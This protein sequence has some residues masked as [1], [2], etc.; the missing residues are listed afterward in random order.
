MPTH[1]SPSIRYKL[2]TIGALL[3]MTAAL[4]LTLAVLQW[5]LVDVRVLKAAQA[6]AALKSSNGQR[7]STIKPSTPHR[8]RDL[9]TQRDHAGYQSPA[10]LAWQAFLPYLSDWEASSLSSTP[11]YTLNVVNS[12]DGVEALQ[13]AADAGHPSAQF[14]MGVAAMTG[15]WP[16]VE[17]PPGLSVQEQWLDRSSEQQSSALIL[18]HMAAISGHTEAMLA[19]AYRLEAHLSDQPTK[20]TCPQR[21]PY[22]RAAA[23]AMMDALLADSHSRA[24]VAPPS[25]KH[26]LHQ[27]HLFGG[28]QSKLDSNNKADESSDALQFYHTRALEAGDHSPHA[29]YTLA[30][31]YHYGL[32]GVVQNLTQALEYYELAAGLGHW[33]AAGQAGKF[34]LY[35]M[36][37]AADLYKAQKYFESGMPFGLD[38]CRKKLQLKLQQQNTKSESDQEIFLCDANCLNGMGVLSLLGLPMTVAVDELKAEEHFILAKDQGNKDA[39]YNLAMMKAGWKSHYR[40]LE[41]N[42]QSPKEEWR[43]KDP[44]QLPEHYLTHPEVQAVLTDLTVAASGGHLQAKHRLAKLYETGAKAPNRGTMMTVIQPDCEKAI[45]NYRFIIDTASPERSRRLRTAYKQYVAGDRAASLRNYLIAAETG[46]D[47]AQLNAA[48]LLEQGEC[49]GLDRLSCAKAALRLWKA[50]ADAGHVEA[51]L[52]VGDFYYYGRLRDSHEGIV[53]PFGWA[54][55]LLYP[56]RHL[57]RLFRMAIAELVRLVKGLE[58]VEEKEVEPV[59]QAGDGADD[60]TCAAPSAEQDVEHSLEKDLENAAVYYRS[61]ADRAASPRANYNLAFLYEWGLGL[62]QDFHLAKRHYDLAIS[63]STKMEAE[64][65]VFIALLCLKIHAYVVKVWKTWEARYE[66]DSEVFVPS[67]AEVTGSEGRPVPS[68]RRRTPQPEEVLVVLI[69]HLLSWDTLL[70]V[71]LMAI[72]FFLVELRRTRRRY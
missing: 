52:R 7:P 60:G 34:Y 72:L 49:L 21:L 26:V 61:A 62:K 36:G 28:T 46:S 56:E 12:T 1:L 20:A 57:P 11:L 64:L 37:V 65:P 41:E 40:D 24:K 68:S 13:E 69:E 6:A 9:H 17:Q 23:D 59:C 27:V 42:G 15:L 71:I 18:W 53:G 43:P 10:D 2:Y 50:A 63:G 31:L 39:A 3:I 66:E 4:A 35:G 16:F 48:F 29:A 44:S 54:Q 5:R 47:L 55:Y 30:H 25:D 67:R 14:L 22:Y 70:I 58:V 33:E 51:S 8:Y 45:K 32:R 38:G 19:A